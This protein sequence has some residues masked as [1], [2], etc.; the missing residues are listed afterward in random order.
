MDSD[1]K[2][3]EV[4]NL[5]RQP[6]SSR[7]V[8]RQVERALEMKKVDVEKSLFER[9]VKKLLEEAR[10]YEEEMNNYL[11]ED[12]EKDLMDAIT[13]LEVDRKR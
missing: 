10:F 2:K 7:I 9:K 8:E 12:P 1:K 11:P 5:L 6:E 13:N 4:K 3:N